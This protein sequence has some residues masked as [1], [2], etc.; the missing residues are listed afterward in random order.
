[1]FG[2]CPDFFLERGSRGMPSAKDGMIDIGI[3]YRAGI[4]DIQPLTLRV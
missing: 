2:V 4:S 1:M 3:V